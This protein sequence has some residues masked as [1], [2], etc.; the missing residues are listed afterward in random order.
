MSQTV[1]I[2]AAKV[3]DIEA[4]NTWS[5]KHVNVSESTS[6]KRLK[7]FSII[8]GICLLINKQF[9]NRKLQRCV[10]LVYLIAYEVIFGHFYV[11]GT[12]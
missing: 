4:G 3:E 11:Y 7:L 6:Q 8:L 1:F 2:Y 12:A 5:S 10:T 9:Y